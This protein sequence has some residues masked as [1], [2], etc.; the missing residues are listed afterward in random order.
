MFISAF[1]SGRFRVIDLWMI[2]INIAQKSCHCRTYDENHQIFHNWITP[3][4]PKFVCANWCKYFGRTES[5][6]QG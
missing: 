2:I 5:G 3:F 4:S 6:Y 1:K